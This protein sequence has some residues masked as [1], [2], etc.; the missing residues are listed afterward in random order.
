MNRHNQNLIT[1]VAILAL[2]AAFL[3]AVSRA[4][5][6][7]DPSTAALIGGSITI[8]SSVKTAAPGQEFSV[9]VKFDAG[10]STVN[11]IS[12]SITISPNL[13]VKSVLDGD[14][15]LP[16]WIE[17]PA[18]SAD[19][20]EIS[21]AGIVPGGFYGQGELFRLIAVSSASGA[22]TL[23]PHDF[24]ALAQGQTPTP[25]AVKLTPFSLKIIGPA[26]S[27]TEAI[28]DAVPPEAFAVT[29]QSDRNAFDGAPFAVFSTTDKQ[30]GIDRYEAAFSY[31]FAPGA[32]DWQS[33]QS[34]YLI[35]AGDSAKIL[36]VSAVDHAG[37]RRIARVILPGYYRDAT[38]L[39][40]ITALILCLGYYAR[41]RMRSRRSP[42]SL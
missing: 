9:D 26:A 14:S 6:P 19:G 10:D 2:F 24:E 7:A 17:Q 31:F 35:P 38:I 11:A 23:K 28:I 30:S 40:I 8:V 29:V 22:A 3:P 34:P 41:Q 25:I 39:A 12:G 1:T 4:A 15:I 27:S 20:R 16:I 36:W 21:F 18:V 13:A 5:I 32:A 33:A 37:N 42:S